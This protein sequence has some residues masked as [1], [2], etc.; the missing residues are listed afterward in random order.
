MNLAQKCNSIQNVIKYT[1][2][3]NV[4]HSVPNIKTLENSRAHNGQSFKSIVHVSESI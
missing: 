1:A 4:M 3:P 2:Q